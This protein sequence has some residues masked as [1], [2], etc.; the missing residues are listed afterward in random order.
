MSSEVIDMNIKPVFLYTDIIWREVVFPGFSI[1]FRFFRF[2]LLLDSFHYLRLPGPPWR[3]TICY[4]NHQS[5]LMTSLNYSHDL[6][7][8]TLEFVLVIMPMSLSWVMFAYMFVM[9]NT[10]SKFICH[11]YCHTGVPCQSLVI[12]SLLCYD[13]SQSKFFNQ[14]FGNIENILHWFICQLF[15]CNHFTLTG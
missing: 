8:S 11:L 1:Y 5:W 13:P 12:S 15:I 3:Q 7:L 10:R 9:T 2:F 14:V 4:W 6:L